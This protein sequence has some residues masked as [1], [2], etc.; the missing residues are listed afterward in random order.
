VTSGDRNW[1][2][3]NTGLQD[4]HAADLYA[5][6]E[7]HQERRP[8]DQRTPR[9]DWIYRG[10]VTSRDAAYR[11]HFGTSRPELAWFSKDSR[12]YIFDLSYTLDTDVFDHMLDRA[13]ERSGV[14]AD[15][16]DEAV[17]NYLRGTIDALLPKIRRNY[18][19]AIPMYYIEVGRMQLL[20]PFVSYS[21][22][23]VA[24]L[25]VERNDEHRCYTVRT[26][27][28]MDQAFF[29]A[30]LLTRPDKEWLNP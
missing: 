8:T 5:I 19:T 17:R 1:A 29:A 15:A 20:L 7:R 26:V 4:K 24:C 22:R 21:G 18:K 27:L 9:P 16:S 14:P 11:A 28:D 30:R 25:L 6:F 3:F 23:D 10:S 2:A 13:R 12:D